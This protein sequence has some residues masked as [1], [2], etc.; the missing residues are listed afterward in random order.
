MKRVYQIAN[1]AAL[2]FALVANY[3]VDAQ[4]LNVPG[5]NEVSDAYATLLT[6]ATYAFSIWSLI[7]AALIAFAIYQ[8]R[9]LF[10]PRKAN[11]L[12]LKMGW[13]FVIASICNGLWTYVF[14]QEY[15]TLSLLI[16]LTLTASLYTL[17]WRL[18]IAVHD[19]PFKT[20]ALVWWPLLLYTGWVTVATLVNYASWLAYLGIDVPTWLAVLLV[21]ML[22]AGLLWL[23]AERNVRELLLASAWGIAAIG[24][25]QV[26][27]DG[28]AVVAASA[29][30]ATGAL[31]VAVAVHAYWN[32][33]S[34]PVKR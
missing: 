28:N 20:I 32:R 25:R 11:D 18:R 12:P 13:L 5:I 29:F 1:I 21:G 17:L 34:I 7:Y 15:V 27:L 14:V 6:P 33:A 31:L 8:A 22:T 19:A 3:L 16:L 10:K 24:F 26:E 30:T 9:D 23:L 4:V 2:S